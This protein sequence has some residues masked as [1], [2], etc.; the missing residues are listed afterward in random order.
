[1]AVR[2]VLRYSGPR[3]GGSDDS[4]GATGENAEQAQASRTRWASRDLLI[5]AP[6]LA[7]ETTVAAWKTLEGQR[8]YLGALL[9]RF[10]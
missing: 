8:A 6:L 4:D 2:D 3:Q 9:C 10:T 5:A 7:I 1:M